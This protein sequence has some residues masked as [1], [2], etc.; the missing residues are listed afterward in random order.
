MN[1]CAAIGPSVLEW[2]KLAEIQRP[3]RAYRSIQGVVA[4]SKKYPA[5]V[6]NAAC[7]YAVDQSVYSYH[8]VKEQAEF[9]RMQ[10]EIQ[11]EIRFTQESHYIRSPKEY[12]KLLNED[13]NG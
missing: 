12:Q 1:R 5:S 11:K 13:A 6:V 4:L 7:R 9:I 2:A 10:K 3:I 8:I